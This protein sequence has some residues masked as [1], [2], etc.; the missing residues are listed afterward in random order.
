[1][2]LATLVSRVPTTK[3]IEPSVGH[4]GKRLIFGRCC[5]LTLE[6]EIAWQKTVGIGIYCSFCDCIDYV[7]AYSKVKK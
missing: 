5:C 7:F 6:R 2:A 3:D 1:M 4:Y